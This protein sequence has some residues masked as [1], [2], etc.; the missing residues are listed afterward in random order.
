MPFFDAPL[1]REQLASLV[2]AG[3]QPDQPPEDFGGV[4]SGSPLQPLLQRSVDEFPARLSSGRH[5]L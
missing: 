5:S 3:A 4:L 2:A 1:P